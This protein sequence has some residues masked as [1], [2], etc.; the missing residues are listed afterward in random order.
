MYSHLDSLRV[1]SLSVDQPEVAPGTTVT[2][3]PYVSDA[4]GAGRA[5]TYSA[6]SCPDP[7]TSQGVTASCLG[8][9]LATVIATNL[10]VTLPTVAHSYTGFVNA[11][12]V[13]VP[14]NILAGQSSIN[15]YNGVSYLVAYSLTAADGTTTSAFR[16]IIASQGH[17]LNTNPSITDILSA[18]VPF[19][20][21]PT[22]V[23]TLVP[24]IPSAAS[25]AY[26]FQDSSGSFVAAT[27]SLLMTWFTNAGDYQYI[28]TDLVNPN[29]F[30]PGKTAPLTGHNTFVFVLRDRRGGEAVLQR[31]F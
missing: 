18:G 6:S 1:L 11:F 30:T 13:T 26:T 17:A 4:T 28:R 15:T 25:E 21:M 14:A 2:I 27:E 10:P 7:G 19:T 22:M 16:R 5:L 20:P 29:Q 31:D 23:T 8:S 24:S 3:T 12:S 9:P